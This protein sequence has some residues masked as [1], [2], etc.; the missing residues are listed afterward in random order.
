MM[1]RLGFEVFKSSNGMGGLELIKQHSPDLIMLDNIMPKLTGWELTKILK[2]DANYADYRNIPII[3][4]SAMG[5]V[6]D[7]IEGFELGIEDYITK[8]FNFLEVLARIRAVLRNHELTN[9]VILREKRLSLTDSLNK[10]LMYFTDHLKEPV[11]ALRKS[12]QDLESSDEKS[13]EKFKQSV[14]DESERVLAALAGLEDEVKTLKESDLNVR[15]SELSLDE[16]DKRY[17]EHFK[18]DELSSGEVS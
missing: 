5:A 2:Q 12:A 13:I 8:P 10:S 17:H 18:H 15:K 16:L 14:V 9:Q 7:K 1:S 6:K 3:M 11:T 4:F